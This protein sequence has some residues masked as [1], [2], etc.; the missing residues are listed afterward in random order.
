M[1]LSS[2][3]LCLVLSMASNA[4]ADGDFFDELN[5]IKAEIAENSKKEQADPLLQ[6]AMQ[7]LDKSEGLV[8]MLELWKSGKRWPA[9][10]AW[11]K[12][13][14][15]N[16]RKL[17]LALFYVSYADRDVSQFPRFEDNCNRFNDE[18]AKQRRREILEVSRNVDRLKIILLPLIEK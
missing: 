14:Y 11:W 17:A 6:G 4:D 3:F 16:T 10:L 9:E 7:S 1:K 15:P 5:K 13:P 8:A 2:M 18:E 12:S